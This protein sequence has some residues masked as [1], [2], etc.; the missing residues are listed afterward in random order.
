MSVQ[1]GKCYGGMN[2]RLHAVQAMRMDSALCVAMRTYER[3]PFR[4][5]S[6]LVYYKERGRMEYRLIREKESNGLMEVIWDDTDDEVVC[7]TG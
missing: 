7:S 4:R 1:L 3:V 6:I 2:Q 5:R